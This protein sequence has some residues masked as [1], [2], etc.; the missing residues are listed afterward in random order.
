MVDARLPAAW[1]PFRTVA[2]F[3]LL[4]SGGSCIEPY[5]PPE[6]AGGENFLVVDGFLNVNGPTLIRLSRSQNLTDPEKPPAEERAQVS[7][8]GERGDQYRLVESEKG[9]YTLSSVAFGADQQYRLRI[10]TAEGK[11]YL[12]EY[13]AVKRTPPID[14]VNW[15][16]T[17][18]GVQV[19]INTHD[20]R[21]DTRYYRWEFEETWEFT[22]PYRANYV[23]NRGKITYVSENITRCWKT[24]P[25]T[26]I[27]LG[28]SSR[29]SEDVIYQYPLVLMP[30][31]SEKH[32]IRYSV[33][34]RQ[35]ALTRQGYDYWQNLKKN[36]ESLGTLFDPQPSQV[37]GNIQQ[38][39]N[40]EE[41]VFG[42]FSV[43]SPEEKRIF[44]T[45]RE[46]PDWG[47]TTGY[48]ACMLDTIRP[49]PDMTTRVFPVVYEQTENGQ[50]VGY[51]TSSDFCVDCRKAGTNVMPSFW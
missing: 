27:V 16:L 36:T 51:I 7:V 35:Y 48:E 30:P 39:N 11:E 47:R 32:R 21:N 26:S 37:L 25:S 44:I 20:P 40:P 14:S 2:L 17:S 18:D 24:F 13:V 23:Y 50:V 3:G 19:Y 46:L 10:R 8:E 12:S 34:V 1:R 5:Q 15:A 38:V 28:T 43:S 29:L 42:F 49:T 22:T 33:L 9:S 4:L 41:P 45:R 6:V 31:S